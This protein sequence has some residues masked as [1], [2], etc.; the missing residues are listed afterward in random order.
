[1]AGNLFPPTCITMPKMALG[2]Q[3]AMVGDSV[4]QLRTT[5]DEDRALKGL[6]LDAMQQHGH[7]YAVGPG[8]TSVSKPQNFSELM[9]S[10]PRTWI[11]PSNTTT[12]ALSGRT[13]NQDRTCEE[14]CIKALRPG[15]TDSVTRVSVKQNR[16]WDSNA[17]ADGS[18]I[19]ATQRS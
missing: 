12:P 5:N 19:S 16:R 11:M 3:L 1:M 2:E 18:K 14:N 9:R 10:S 8:M 6:H 17:G 7:R 15:F 4:G 13:P